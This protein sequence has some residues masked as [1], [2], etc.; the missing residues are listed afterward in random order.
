MSPDAPDTPPQAQPKIGADEWVASHDRRRERARRRLGGLRAQRSSVSAAGAACSPSASPR[1]SLPLLTNNGYVLRV[2]FDTLIYMLL[3][4][5]L[6]IVVGFAGL[7]DLGLRRVLRLRRLRLRDAR[8]VASSASTG[9][10]RLILTVVT[11]ATVLLG[12]LVAL[13]LAAP[14]RRL[15][16]DR[17]PLLRPAVR[18]GDEQRQPDLDPRL[19]ARLQ[20]HERPE[21]DREHRSVPP[22][23]AYLESLRATTTSRCCS[24]WS[25]SAR[26]TSSAPRAPG[27]RGARCARTRSR[28]R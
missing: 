11:G 25:S 24:S 14:R 4:L 17:D 9:R 22:L 3:A 20:R 26:S 23:R 21:R 18:D 13:A 7:L 12:L 27:V 19:H 6:N 10:R 28:P 5:G 8:L 15:P 16:R 2:G 1:R